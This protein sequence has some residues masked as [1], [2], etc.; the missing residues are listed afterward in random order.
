M[1]NI[2]L[3]L[4][5]VL[6]ERV[7][8]PLFG[9]FVTSWA[10]VNWKTWYI[11]FWDN[12][13]GVDKVSEVS[14]I[15]HTL[16]CKYVDYILLPALGTVIYVFIYPIVSKYIFKIHKTYLEEL[17]SIKNKIEGQTLLT[18]EQSDE[19]RMQ[20]YDYRRGHIQSLR[21][22]DNEI[23][24]LTGRLKSYE[25]DAQLKSESESNELPEDKE[26]KKIKLLGKLEQ[27]RKSEYNLLNDIAIKKVSKAIRDGLQTVHLSNV[28]FSTHNVG[29]SAIANFSHYAL[30]LGFSVDI[31][32]KSGNMAVVEKISWDL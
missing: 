16:N 31:I 1:D 3:S 25:K 10:I 13:V 28:G 6:Y 29:R 12:R 17:V 32:Y 4:K 15:V 5:G 30:T 26:S 9:S 23:A 8:S 20:L 22:K 2:I 11:L 27:L 19:I 7:S 24:T 21:E 18:R 14:K